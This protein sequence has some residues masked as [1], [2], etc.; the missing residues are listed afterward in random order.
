MK[1]VT[2]KDLARELGLS[3]STV[4]RALNGDRNIRPELVMQ[5]FADSTGRQFRSSMFSINRD[6]VFADL[7]DG[8]QHR[9]VS[10]IDLGEEDEVRS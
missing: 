1:R 9:F 6:E 7:G 4:S 2:L 10:L 5:A 3:S 8:R